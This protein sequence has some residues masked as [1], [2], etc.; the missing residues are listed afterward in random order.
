[1]RVVGVT[2]RWK[3]S[4]LEQSAV[5]CGLVRVGDGCPCHRQKEGEIEF[6]PGFR[7]RV[8]AA[9][10]LASTAR[11]GSRSCL[12]LGRPV[13]QCVRHG[14][15]KRWTEAIARG[16]AR[17]LATPARG[18]SA[19][20][21][22]LSLSLASVVNEIC[23]AAAKLAAKFW[24]SALRRIGGVE[25]GRVA[26]LCRGAKRLSTLAVFLFAYFPRPRGGN[27]AKLPFVWPRVHPDYGRA[28]FLDSLF[29]IFLGGEECLATLIED[30]K[31]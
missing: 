5:R 7:T 30:G 4:Q 25:S 9:G 1:M 21:W 19:P 3:M 14:R 31:P 27:A 12:G 22:P 6:R 15:E 23:F 10:P 28:S 17:G 8:P 13:H 24:R 11:Y 18:A 16:L 26:S 20:A 29:P 2:L